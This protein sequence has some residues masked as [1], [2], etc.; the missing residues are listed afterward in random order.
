M[1][2]LLALLLSLM[3]LLSLGAAAAETVTSAAE[4]LYDG[5]WVRFED[6]FEIYLPSE[7]YQYETTEEHHALGIFYI[8][9][10]QDFS[11][12][13]MMGW[14]QLNQDCTIEQ[15]HAEL[16]TAYPDAKIMDV[17]GVG[18]VYY[19]DPANGLMCYVALDATEPGMYMMGFFPMDNEEMKTLSALIASTLRCY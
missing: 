6:G 15:L 12:G 16:V 13:F 11:R 8:A 17:S 1:K 2:K 5:A 18:L 10:T 7:W 9:G 14:Q 19:E 4:M 3:M